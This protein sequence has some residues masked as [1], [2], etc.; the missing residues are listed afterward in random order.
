MY[1]KGYW[2]NKDSRTFMSRGYLSENES[3]EERIKNIAHTF[4]KYIGIQDIGDKFEDYMLRGWYSLASP[5]WS[6]YGLKR[7]LPISCNGSALNDSMES[8]LYKTAEIGMMTKNGAGTSAYFGALRPRGAPIS[9]GGTSSGAVSFM[10]LLDS[11]TNV[12]SQSNVRRGSC[13]VY[14]DV[15]HS[16]IKEF[17]RIR[18]EG[19]PIQHLSIGVCITDDWMQ[20][21]IDGD[22][23]KR[24]IWI[25]IIEKRTE[26]GYPYI[27]FTD[28]VNNNKPVWYKNYQIVASNLCTETAIPS[29]EN[30]SFVC[31][32]SSMNV[33]HYDDWKKTDA[34]QVLT[35][36]LDT[37]ITEYVEKTENMMFMEA[38]NRFA[39]NHRAIG[40][41]ILGLHS[42]FQDNMIPFESNIARDVNLHVH[43]YIDEQSDIATE[44]L[45]KKFGEAP[46]C[47]GYGKRNA[48]R[49]ATAPTTSSSFIL[50]QVS[51]SREPLVSNYFIKD[52]AKGKFTYKNPYL[53]KLLKE[54]KKDDK[55]TWQSIL[56]N[57]GSVQH[58]DFLSD[59]EKKVF[60]TFG[61]IPQYE[62]IVQAAI[63]QQFID[64]GQSLNLMI[65]PDTPL[66][67]INKLMIEA[68]KLGVKTLY[69]QRGTNPAQE[70]A[71]QL[72]SC[73]ACE[74]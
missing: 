33:L 29:N 10:E 68:W 64:Q 30:E 69:Y 32:L 42:Y 49:M 54:Y 36:F 26:T 53:K 44:W 73:V 56:M 31:C 16:D 55:E 1:E 52:L 3:I 39:K 63:A 19:H 11:I 46:V 60:K 47:K 61:E 9:A 72:S 21:M 48:T 22:K 71:R 24:K 34:V 2:I 4:E 50:G 66:K 5:I 43:Q 41:G 7:G 57:G 62:L 18:D 38:A 27:F 65:H 15:E 12:V 70:Y 74:V 40:I 35:Y 45:A 25:R 6:N 13:A 51:P 8:I 23:D 37:V 58:L 28:T 14:L 20:S 59:E 17:L 67:D